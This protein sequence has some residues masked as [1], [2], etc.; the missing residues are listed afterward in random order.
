MASYIR[1][2]K[3][4]ATLGGAA[5]WPL[6]ARAEQS[7]MP[8]IG[9][10]N[11]GLP[12]GFAPMVGAFHQGLKE[13]GY[14]E[15][16]NVAI[17]YRWAEGRYDRL[18][19]LAADLVGRKVTVLAATTTPA[20]LAAKAA[21]STVPIVFTTG[22]DPIKLG[23]VASLNRPG[24]NVTGVSN[25]IAEL[26]SK[27]LGL[28]RE[29]VP[30]ANVIAMLM[31]P[32]FPDGERQLRD[33]E[34]A[35]RALGLQLIVVR[36][37]TD[38]EI[39]AAFE[40]IAHQGGDVLLVAVDPF[41]F[42]RRDHIVALASRRAIPALYPVRDF[43]VAG[44]LMSYATDFADS[45]RQAGIYSGRI[46]KGEKPADLPVQQSVKFELVINLKAAKALGLSVPNSMQLLADE[47]IE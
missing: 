35:V 17:E 24:G 9:F 7:A 33:V 30:R 16:Q 37:G 42:A 28:L 43:A 26:A 1:R 19:A 8:V 4:L 2:R 22:N 41:L 6:A 3:F 13:T 46:V 25:L 45:Y 14:I 36:A 10:L 15:S 44:G 18:P 5:A 31:N 47:V 40:T 38:R 34:A 32:N 11:G 29:L 21:T 23:L 20:A 27:R 39:D 12:D